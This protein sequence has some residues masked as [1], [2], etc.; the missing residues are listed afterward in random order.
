MIMP[1]AA[2]TSP[3]LQLCFGRR[4]PKSALKKPYN[5]NITHIVISRSAIAP[6]EKTD[7]RTPKKPRRQPTINSSIT[8]ITYRK[9]K[10]P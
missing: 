6:S 5:T 10:T 9:T 8:P 2:K 1:G 7:T 3:D 4:N